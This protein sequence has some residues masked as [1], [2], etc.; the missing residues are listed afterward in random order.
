MKLSRFFVERPGEGNKVVYSEEI[1]IGRG[2]LKA[3]VESFIPNYP[4]YNGLK[5]TGYINRIVN[6]LEDVRNEI[7]DIFNNEDKF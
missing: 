3:K 4:I 7:E 6:E 2:E 1:A 5:M